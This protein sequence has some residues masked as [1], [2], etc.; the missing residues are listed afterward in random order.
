MIDNLNFI[1][2]N[3]IAKFLK[4]QEK[5]WK[6]PDCGEWFAATTASASTVA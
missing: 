2:E 6:C 1:K 5:T 4:D 3:G